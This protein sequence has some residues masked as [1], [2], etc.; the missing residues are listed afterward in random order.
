[1]S[2]SPVAV[3]LRY[4]SL[5]PAPFVVASARGELARKLIGLAQHEGIPVQDAPDLANRLVWLRPGEL[6]PPSVYGLVAEI[7]VQ[8]MQLEQEHGGHDENSG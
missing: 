3:G 2:D 7:L 6:I 4:D 1:M 5:T 8:V